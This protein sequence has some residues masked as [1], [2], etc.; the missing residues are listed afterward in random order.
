MNEHRNS[1]I[2]RYIYF[3][4]KIKLSALWS[5]YS[6]STMQEVQIILTGIKIRLH[7]SYSFNSL[8]N[9]IAF[10][11]ISISHSNTD[12]SGVHKNKYT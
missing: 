10:N 2:Y 9:S 8:G 7:I 4:S 11:K 3:K 1:F 6:I 12:M 5:P